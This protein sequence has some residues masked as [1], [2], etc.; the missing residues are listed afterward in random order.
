MKYIE[1]SKADVLVLFVIVFPYLFVA[2]YLLIGTLYFQFPLFFTASMASIVIGIISW[3]SHIVAAN[4]TRYTIAGYSNT[5]KRVCIQFPIYIILSILMGLSLFGLFNILGYINMPLTWDNFRSLFVAGIILN[6]AATSFHEGLYAFHKWKAAMLETE[7]LKKNYLQSQLE[8][9]KNQVNP[10]F[11]FNSLNSVSALIY[12]NPE[13]AV[14]FVDEMSKVYRYLLRS[15]ERWLI[16]LRAEL[17]FTQSFF[18][19]LKTRHE[20][21]IELTIDVPEAYLDHLL[22]PLTLQM[23]L[24]NAVKHNVVARERPLKIILLVTNPA[25]LVVRNNIQKRT[26]T[27][28]STGIGLQNIMSKYRLLNDS[29]VD[30]LDDGKFFT[31]KLPIIPPNE[32]DYFDR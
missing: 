13:K 9:L 3:A 17:S 1:F 2:N 24:E 18:H 19:M 10:H 27:V 5:V 31:V 23:L 22:P 4:I 15:N 30:V 32:Y 25:Q 28:L 26:T 12:T 16:P 8:G 21:G 20:E 6:V 11:L 7:Q 29:T 14:G